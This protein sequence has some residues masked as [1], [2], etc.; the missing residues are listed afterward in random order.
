MVSIDFTYFQLLE[1]LIKFKPLPP[2]IAELMK[3]KKPSVPEN[4]RRRPSR[5]WGEGVAP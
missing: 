4:E 2:K 1:K 5:E 3:E